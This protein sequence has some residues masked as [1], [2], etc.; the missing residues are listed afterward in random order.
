MFICVWRDETNT[1]KAFIDLPIY[2][3]AMTEYEAHRDFNSFI[4][5]CPAGRTYYL[6]NE[7]MQPVSC[8][9]AA[10]ELVA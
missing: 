1:D 7:K 9:T 10:K 6:L 3:V 4:M 5:G 2:W 8:F